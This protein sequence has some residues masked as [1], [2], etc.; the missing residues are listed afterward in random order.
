MPTYKERPNIHSQSFSFP[1]VSYLPQ[2]TP[3]TS[4]V[5]RLP[6]LLV[7]YLT[8]TTATS[9]KATPHGPQLSDQQIHPI[10][11]RHPP[12]LPRIE[13]RL[14]NRLPT[15]PIHHPHHDSPD[16]PT[17]QHSSR[18]YS[19]A[20]C[21]PL[22]HRCPG[23]G[24]CRN[25]LR[26]KH[27]IAVIVVIAGRLRQPQ[28][29]RAGAARVG[30]REAGRARTPEGLDVVRDVGDEHVEGRACDVNLGTGG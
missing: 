27:V 5:L 6:N 23:P 22:L 4:T 20:A 24:S 10:M 17:P 11:Q 16:T 14:F 19:S 1:L 13:L 25:A 2:C 28:D 9:N 30:E 3:S 8:P 7:Q 18:Q 29:A 15:L 12:I 26:K 21:A